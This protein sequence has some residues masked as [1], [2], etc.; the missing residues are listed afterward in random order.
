MA[1]YRTPEILTPAGRDADLRKQGVMKI[2]R[3]KD[4]SRLKKSDGFD[5]ANGRYGWL[6][7]DFFKTGW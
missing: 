1:Q 4:E 3:P 2:T 5:P 6:G 7:A